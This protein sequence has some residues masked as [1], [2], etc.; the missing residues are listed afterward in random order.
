[1][2]AR[3]ILAGLRTYARRLFDSCRSWRRFLARRFGSRHAGLP[4]RFRFAGLDALE[5]R[6][7][8]GSLLAASSL[9]V[10]ESALRRALAP[11]AALTQWL[12]E[13]PAA[14]P[15]AEPEAADVAAWL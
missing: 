14:A 8:P 6:E 7:K 9:P 5:A 10:F 11:P 1:M 12:P 4:L 13:P 15:Q 2:L 3:R